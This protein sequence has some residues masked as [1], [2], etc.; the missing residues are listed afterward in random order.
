[1][2]R[3]KYYVFS[4]VLALILL[5][6]CADYQYTHT[7][8]ENGESVLLLATD[9]TSVLEKEAED[10]GKTF[11]SKLNEFEEEKITE[12]NEIME[13]SNITCEVKDA[14]VE[15]SMAFESIDNSSGFGEYYTFSKENEVS[16]Y[17]Y[18]IEIKKIPNL[19]LMDEFLGIE[20]IDLEKELT[21]DEKLKLDTGKE[22]D[23]ILEYSV[24]M[25]GNVEE[26]YFGKVEGKIE[27]NKVTFN[28]LDAGEKS[29]TIFVKSRKTDDSFMGVVLGLGVL[30]FLGLIYVIFLRSSP[31]K[32]R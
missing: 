10:E 13:N 2:K 20:E 15:I 24:V 32:K 1:M 6:G 11:S 19:N 9:Y 30:V 14:V 8:Q 21:E 5:F 25:P 7:V 4:I 29:N 31:N 28:L 18:I 27:G 17:V 16:S 12:C 3:R 22:L 23:L 26:A